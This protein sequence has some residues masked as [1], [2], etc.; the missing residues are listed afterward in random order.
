MVVCIVH[1]STTLHIN[2]HGSIHYDNIKCLSMIL[3]CH[4]ENHRHEG[5]LYF[6]LMLVHRVHWTLP[7]LALLLQ[8]PWWIFPWSWKSVSCIRYGHTHCQ[9]WHE[10]QC[11]MAQSAPL[12][13]SFLGRLSN[14]F[15]LGWEFLHALILFVANIEHPFV[16]HGHTDRGLKLSLLGSLLSKRV[17]EGEIRVKHLNMMTTY[18]LLCIFYNVSQCKFL[19]NFGI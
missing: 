16:I 18:C 8:T 1:D 14:K 12:S 17:R 10:W 6:H 11:H 3:V 9:W 13:C 5:V 4:L 7:P 15:T 19:L 2:N